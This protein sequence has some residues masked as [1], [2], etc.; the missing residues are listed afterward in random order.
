MPL[1]TPRTGEADSEFVS[2]CMHEIS[3][4]EFPDQKQ[5]NAVCYSQL[6][7]K[8]FT[9]ESPNIIIKSFPQTLKT[10]V[11]KEES[12]ER[13]YMEVP[14]SGTSWDRDEERMSENALKSMLEQLKSGK[15]PV[16]S[17]HGLDP[18]G[19]RSYRWQDTIGKWVD[20]RIE[21]QADTSLLLFGTIM[22]NEANPDA[23]KF[24]DYAKAG[25]PV[26]FSVGGKCTKE[27]SEEVEV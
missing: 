26:G 20:G 19:S 22:R 18:N 8:E 9:L 16:F 10:W 5:R 24:W 1:P 21:K 27:S 15:V 17:N 4:K 3:E 25:M 14:L 2:R 23:I 12:G 7:K 11:S 13:N 6:K